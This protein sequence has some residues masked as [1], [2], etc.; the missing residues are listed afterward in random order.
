[1]GTGV[2]TSDYSCG[3]TA[4]DGVGWDVLYGISQHDFKRKQLNHIGTGE[5]TL[6]T[7][8]P[9][10]TVL[11]LPIVL[12]G[13]MVTPPPIQQSGSMVIFLPK[14]GPLEPSRRLGSTGKVAV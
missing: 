4:D 11:P 12:P 3:V 7:M 5:H 13:R 9:A 8:D 2:K 10:P 6:V 14:L 1:M